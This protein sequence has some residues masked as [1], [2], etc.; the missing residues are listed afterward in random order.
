MGGWV[1]FW[2]PSQFGSGLELGLGLGL[3]PGLGLGLGLGLGVACLSF[4]SARLIAD[5][6]Q[7]Q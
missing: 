4:A 6:V 2:L 3:G 1:G 7:R 5:S